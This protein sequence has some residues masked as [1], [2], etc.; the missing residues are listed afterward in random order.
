M[1]RPLNTSQVVMT[2]IGEAQRMLGQAPAAISPTTLLAFRDDAQRGG[3]V[4]SLSL[5]LLVLLDT[6]EAAGLA[7]KT[8]PYGPD[9]PRGGDGVPPDPGGRH[10]TPRELA[11]AALGRRLGR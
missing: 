10:A 3:P 7:D 2:A 6:F 4:L 9:E 1:T 8:Q 11:E 5:A